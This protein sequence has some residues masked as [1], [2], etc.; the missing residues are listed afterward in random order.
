MI[1]LIT[2]VDDK[3]NLSLR[4]SGGDVATGAVNQHDVNDRHRRCRVIEKNVR[5]CT[6]IDSDDGKSG[7]FQHLFDIHRNER[8]IFE[9]EGN[10][11]LGKHD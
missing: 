7:A 4:Q 8:L 10:R 1:R 2:A 6:R 5:I 9:H 3:G 11:P